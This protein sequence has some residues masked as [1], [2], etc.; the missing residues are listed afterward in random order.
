MERK[1]TFLVHVIRCNVDDGHAGTR[2]IFFQQS[3]TCSLDSSVT[4]V[5]LSP[6]TLL[7]TMV[8]VVKLCVAD[9]GL[10]GTPFLLNGNAPKPSSTFGTILHRQLVATTT[11]LLKFHRSMPHV[12]NPCCRADF[13]QAIVRLATHCYISQRHQASCC[14]DALKMLLQQDL[15]VR[16]VKVVLHQ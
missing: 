15:R 2:T 7:F 6:S 14:A 10:A 9:Q 3:L 4:E 11:W 5:P 16:A 12:C 13:Y 8:L 1:D